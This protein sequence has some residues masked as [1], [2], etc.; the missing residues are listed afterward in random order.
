M[1]DHAIRAPSLEAQLYRLKN[2]TNA[3]DTM[4]MGLINDESSGATDIGR[5]LLFMAETMSEN[6]EAIHAAISKANATHGLL[7]TPCPLVYEGG[8]SGVEV[9]DE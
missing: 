4:A 9:S 1:A 8:P 6:V 5:S 2:A 7:S 3:L